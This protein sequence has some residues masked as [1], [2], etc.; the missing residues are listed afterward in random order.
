MN[1]HF[2]AMVSR[3]KYIDRWALM[4]NTSKENLY[5]HSFEVAVI[6]HALCIIS[7]E[8]FGTDYDAEHAAAVALYHDF[9]EILTGDMPTPVKYRNDEIKTAYKQVEKEA[10]RHLLELL[11]ED[12]LPHYKPVLSCDDEALCHIIKAAD[13]LSALIKCIE[14]GKMGN[15]EFDKAKDATLAA[16]HALGEPAAEVFIEE[17]LPSYNLTLDELK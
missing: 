8:R 9:S 12:I 13:K 4:K 17:F 15:R 14:E 1:S 3:M 11:P 7:N 16:I 5:E 6:A 10:E 2:F